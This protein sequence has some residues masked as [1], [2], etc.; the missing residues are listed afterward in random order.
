MELVMQ[1]LSDKQ[2]MRNKVKFQPK[3]FDTSLLVQ[4]GKRTGNFI[5]CSG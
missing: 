5:D 2:L 1:R 4:M 3:H